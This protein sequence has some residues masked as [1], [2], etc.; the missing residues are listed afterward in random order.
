MNAKPPRRLTPAQP[1]HHHRPPD[2]GIEFHCEHP[3]GPAMPGTDI[4][5]PYQDRYTLAPLSRRRL[6]TGLVVH[7][8]T[9][10]YNATNV[11]TGDG[12]LRRYFC[13]AP[14]DSSCM[15]TGACDSISL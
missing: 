5:K 1:V 9:A 10:V 12:R 15:A 4:E 11:A 6:N 3:S 14:V 13:C 2:P 7:F 8:A